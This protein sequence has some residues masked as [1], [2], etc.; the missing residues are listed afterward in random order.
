MFFIGCLPVVKISILKLANKITKNL[1]FRFI[2]SHNDYPEN[3][4]EG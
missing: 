4:S 1:W 2:I 3:F